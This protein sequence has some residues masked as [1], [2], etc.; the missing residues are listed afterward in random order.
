MAWIKK[1][2]SKYK[3]YQE[4]AEGRM[5]ER[6]RKAKKH[7]EMAKLKAE[8]RKYK[9]THKPKPGIGFGGG[10]LKTDIHFDPTGSSGK[11][12]FGPHSERTRKRKKK[13]RKK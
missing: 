1:A 7:V 3:K 8:E 9:Q 5:D 2:Y 6:L 13:A 11:Q 10:I 4:G 12:I